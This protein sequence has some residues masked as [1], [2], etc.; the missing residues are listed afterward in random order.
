MAARLWLD[1][2]CRALPYTVM[3]YDVA[4][5]GAGIGG[6]SLAAHLAR[7]AKTL[8]LEAEDRPGY[9]STGRSAAFYTET[10]G[11]RAVQ[12]LTLASK[13]WY[14][15]THA[16]QSDRLMV[17]RRGAVHVN[18]RQ[19]DAQ[20]HQFYGALAQLSDGL[21]LVDAAHCTQMCPLVPQADV[22]GGVYDADCCDIDVAS[23]HQYFLRAAKH[24]GVETWCDFRVAELTRRAGIWSISSQRG[25]QVQAKIVVN[26]AGAWADDIARI[27]GATPIG[28]LPKR[29][30]VGVFELKD[31]VVSP[32][33]PLVLD[34][35]EHFYFKP[36]GQALLISPADET[37]SP[38]CD[39]QPEM[40]DIALAADRF[41]KATGHQLGRC[42]AKW[43]GLRTFAPDRSPVFGFDRAA[44]DFFWCAGQGGFGI[45]T[46]PAAGALCA[47]LLTG[48]ALPKSHTDVG[49]NIDTYAPQR[50]SK[51]A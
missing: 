16:P 51:A 21:E 15:H 36:E 7:D 12:P 25:K 46:A 14:F 19:P 39:A 9:H 28:L 5:I 17:H 22:K 31:A 26:A 6:A 2:R 8:L 47:A 1:A 35:E 4:I 10:Y 3:I 13:H 37:P 24:A 40:E 44:D 45:Q 42:L 50:F 48:K 29:R 34:L 23:V 30:T 11:G 43:A 33:W 32:E 18:W 49:I 41:E 27:A 20:L 38:P